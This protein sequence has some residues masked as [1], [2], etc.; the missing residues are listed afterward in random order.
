MQICTYRSIKTLS[1][2]GYLKFRG[3][4]TNPFVHLIGSWSSL[5]FLDLAKNAKSYLVHR[6]RSKIV[7]RHVFE[8]SI[9]LFLVHT[10][11]AHRIKNIFK[12]S[13]LIFFLWPRRQLL[14]TSLFVI[15]KSV[16][17]LKSFLWRA[18]EIKWSSNFFPVLIKIPLIITFFPI[19]RQT[20][21]S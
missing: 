16:C 12:S 21:I 7:P 8:V 6:C 18:G 1:S 11:Q 13:F 2:L 3:N 5:I 20:Q 14:A 10:F 4:V 17:V 19:K 9:P 15:P